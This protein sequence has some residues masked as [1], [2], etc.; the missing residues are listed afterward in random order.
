MECVFSPFYPCF[1]ISLGSPWLCG[2]YN[3]DVIPS[4]KLDDQFMTSFC[5]SLIISMSFVFGIPFDLYSV[6][7]TKSK[8]EKIILIIVC[9]V[10]E[11]CLLPVCG[12]K[13]T[14]RLHTLCLGT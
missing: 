10:V 6:S 2:V 14:G 9:F 13:Y 12:A 8:N 1:N 5:N 7:K 3:L 4:K 11:F